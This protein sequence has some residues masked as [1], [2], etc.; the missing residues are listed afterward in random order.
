MTDKPTHIC[1]TCGYDAGSK[2]ALKRH[3]QI[4][5]RAP[6]FKHTPLPGDPA[7]ARYVRRYGDS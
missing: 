4:A 6:T 5:H 1:L 2:F 3:N 7:A